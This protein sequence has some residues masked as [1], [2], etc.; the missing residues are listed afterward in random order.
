MNNQLQKN[1]VSPQP[2]PPKIQNVK[3]TQSKMIW[4]KTQF[5]STAHILRGALK[6][7][8]L[9]YYAQSGG[10]AKKQETFD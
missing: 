1:N 6:I 8:N 9:T 2:E 3:V 5:T 7:L 4:I 10:P